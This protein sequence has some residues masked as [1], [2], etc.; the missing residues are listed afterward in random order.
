MKS[1]SSR[2]VRCD[3]LLSWPFLLALAALLLNDW[4][5]KP[6][7]PG[8]VSGF[9]SD[10]AGMVFF[11]ILLVAAAEVLARLTH[12]RRLATPSWFAAS[13]AVIVA[14]FV[15]VKFTPLGEQLYAWLVAPV[16]AWWGPALNLSAT[17]VV[18][19]PWDLLALLLAPVPMLVGRHW[20]PSMKAS[21]HAR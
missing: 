11:P 3:F 2:Q 15:F 10:A 9:L 19:D 21:H 1:R 4:F 20:R 18:S 17:G 14:L 13:A 7:R 6:Y 5:L 16:A 12:G 8:W